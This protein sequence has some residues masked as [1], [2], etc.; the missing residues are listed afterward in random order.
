MRQKS[1]IVNLS[2]KYICPLLILKFTLNQPK[3]YLMILLPF[4]IYIYRQ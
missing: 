4:Y 2:E 3:I 1:L